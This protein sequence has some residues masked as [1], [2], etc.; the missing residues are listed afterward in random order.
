MQYIES[1]LNVQPKSNIT[2]LQTEG[3]V[4]WTCW[5]S[6]QESQPHKIFEDYGGILIAQI[7]QQSL[8]FFFNPEATFYALAR[9]DIWSKQNGFGLISFTFP[10]T[11]VVGKNHIL[12]L[13]VDE[14][15][16]SLFTE[17]PK[18]MTYV[19]AHPKLLPYATSLPGISFYEMTE[20]EKQ[21][22]MGW[23]GFSAD[24]RLPF[25][26]EKGWFAFIHP[27][28]NPLDKGYLE[29]WEK[30]ISY[31]QPMIESSKFK[32][33]LQDTC[34]SVFIPS[35]I[36]LR[37]W[38]TEVLTT[39]QNINKYHQ[40]LYWP[41]L[42]IILDKEN[43]NF[44]H[45]IHETLSIDWD[46]MMPDQMYASYKNAL[47]LGKGYNISDLSYSGGLMQ[48]T[49]LC[50]VQLAGQSSKNSSNSLFAK[51]L[52]PEDKKSCFYCG[53]GG[54][55]AITCPTKTM[56]PLPEGFWANLNYVDFDELESLY[57]R[58]D[59]EVQKEGLNAYANI[60]SSEG[61]ASSFL[62]ATLAVNAICQ[63][64]NIE[65]I[66][67]ITTRNIE[68]Y[69]DSYTLKNPAVPILKRFVLPNQDI[70][71]LERDC[72]NNIAAN[73][74]SWHLHCLL[75]FIHMEK[76]DY[77][78]AR[79]SWLEAEN[80]CTTTVHQAWIRF[81]LGRL[82][83]IQSNY[84]EAYDIY[85][86]LGTL[87]PKWHEVSYRM[88]I[89][90][91]KMGFAQRVEEAFLK[92]VAGKPE[93]MHKIF[94]DPELYRGKLQ[95]VNALQSIWNNA[96][97]EFLMDRDKL[98]Y[99]NGLLELWFY[100]TDNPRMLYGSKIKHYLDFGVIKNYLLCIEV[101][102]LRPQLE[103]DVQRVITQETDIIKGEYENCLKQ[104]EVIRDEMNWFY[105]QSVLVDFNNI[106]NDCAKIL[107]WAFMS[108]FNEVEIYK[109][110]R[111]K[112]PEL[113]DHIEKLK[114]KLTHL[115][116]I[117]DI[118]LFLVLFLKSFIRTALF[119][120][121]SSI[122]VLFGLLFFGSMVGLL[123]L[124]QL[125]HLNFWEIFKVVLYIS[126]MVAFGMTALKT[127]VIFE[128]KKNNLLENAREERIRMQ[129]KRLAETKKK[130][131]AEDGFKEEDDE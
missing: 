81:L 25:N 33:S 48:S 57:L 20:L 60:L 58:I 93:L 109:E 23:K 5:S 116:I 84:S 15:Y 11:L 10:G 64:P 38:V 129:Q 70:N 115:R 14:E 13:E 56:Q 29:G 41:C 63:L 43:H 19:Y 40:D 3:S 104:V 35:I 76:Q 97:A 50:S 126:L 77:K 89:C 65:R 66:W 39:F 91:V 73:Q 62:R 51:V 30:F 88:L 103:K 52:L 95:I 61:T 119:F 92:L 99:L 6:D 100:E 1:I 17:N 85:K 106:Y 59:N 87:M 16:K 110:A 94:L 86:R 112:L 68:D 124:Q 108:N 101:G 127:T 96:N 44:T 113:Q 31:I 18:T 128:K 98:K 74:K 27:I 130:R 37:A 105:F 36:Q 78:S 67:N 79:L 82:Q 4:V 8:W 83:E 34:L 32:F 24:R 125:I 54:H 123:W 42:S 22:L 28:G 111:E 47:L 75:G 122:V 80:L 90:Q 55:T 114:G 53:S 45:N 72:Y 46:N 21:G 2:L 131:Q 107:N 117:R 69:P 71:A 102:K 26:I 12:H 7:S 118:T 9:L 49:D 120:C 121:I